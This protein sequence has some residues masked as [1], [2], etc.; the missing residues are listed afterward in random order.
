[1]YLTCN[2]W[3]LIDGQID[4]VGGASGRATGGGELIRNRADGRTLNWHSRLQRLSRIMS[5]RFVHDLSPHRQRQSSAVAARDNRSRLIESD[6]YTTGQRAGES[7]EP[8]VL[9]IVRGTSLA[10]RR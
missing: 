6:P 8:G 1:M 2:S 4:V 10:C 3:Y 9:V 5:R 7:D